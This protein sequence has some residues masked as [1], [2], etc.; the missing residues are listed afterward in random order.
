MFKG[1]IEIKDFSIWDKVDRRNLASRKGL[2]E[3][4]EGSG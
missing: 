1:E 4:W 3:K 2:K